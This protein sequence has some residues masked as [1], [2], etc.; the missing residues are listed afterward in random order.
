[1]KFRNLFEFTLAEPEFHWY[2]N[3]TK[4][5]IA[6]V[7]GTDN[8]VHIIAFPEKKVVVF[9]IQIGFGDFIRAIESRISLYKESSIFGIAQK[10]G[11]GW[12]LTKIVNREYLADKDLSKWEWLNKYIDLKP[13]SIHNEK[14]E[15]R[16]ENIKKEIKQVSN[17]ARDKFKNMTDV[18]GN[19]T[20]M[21]KTDLDKFIQDY[22]NQHGKN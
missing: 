10:S 21:K 3:P 5:Q 22:N 14:P 1:M 16:T 15:D 17:T 18:K 9:P 11:M 2:E 12:M 4:A 20:G 6:E 7:A 8:K 19:T 13:L